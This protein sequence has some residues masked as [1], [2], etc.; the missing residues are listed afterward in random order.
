MAIPSLNGTF[1]INIFILLLIVGGTITTFYLI[2]FIFT[3]YFDLILKIYNYFITSFKKLFK[4]TTRL[5]ST[6]IF[7]Y[8]VFSFSY[9]MIFFLNLIYFQNP[10]QNMGYL[11]LDIILS[12]VIF[13]FHIFIFFKCVLYY[14]LGEAK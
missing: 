4:I 12:F 2:Y 6:N 10:V 9:L 5:I 11:I 1:T 3:H 13:I 7:P 8:I 14:K